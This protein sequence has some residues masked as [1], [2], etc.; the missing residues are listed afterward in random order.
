MEP[1]KKYDSTVSFE[2]KRLGQVEFAAKIT[3]SDSFLWSKVDHDK[4]KF[5]IFI[6]DKANPDKIVKFKKDFHMCIVHIFKEISLE[7]LRNPYGQ[8]AH[9]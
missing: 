8:P 5:I 1:K 6:D 7:Q 9:S 2:H 3:F 4:Q